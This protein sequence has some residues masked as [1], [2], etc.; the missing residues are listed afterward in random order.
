MPHQNRY[1]TNG[2]LSGIRVL[3][4]KGTIL[5]KSNV[6][7]IFNALLITA[8]VSIVIKNTSNVH[9]FKGCIY[10]YM[11]NIPTLS[12]LLFFLLFRA[13]SL[14]DVVSSKNFFQMRK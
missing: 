11:N 14:C 12:V 8:S 13:I 1:L 10:L 2:K 5:K 9:I 7:F 4:T 3:N 6:S